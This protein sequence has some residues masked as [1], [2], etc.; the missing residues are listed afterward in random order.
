MKTEQNTDKSQ[1]P[2]RIIVEKFG[3]TRPAIFVDGIRRELH[4]DRVLSPSEMS[5]S[6]SAGV[7][8]LSE[9]Q[10]AAHVMTT[11]EVFEQMKSLMPELY[12]TI[13][14]MP[15]GEEAY[16]KAAG[17]FLT[18]LTKIDVR[19]VENRLKTKE[20]L[21]DDTFVQSIQNIFTDLFAPVAVSPEGIVLPVPHKK[22]GLSMKFDLKDYVTEEIQSQK[23]KP[24][25]AAL[26][27]F[28]TS[29]Y[30]SLSFIAK[31]TGLPGAEGWIAGLLINAWESFGLDVM[32]TEPSTTKGGQRMSSESRK[33]IKTLFQK[34]LLYSVP[35]AYLLDAGFTGVGIFERYPLPLDGGV[36]TKALSVAGRLFIAGLVAVAPEISLNAISR[37]LKELFG[38]NR[39]EPTLQIQSALPEVDNVPAG[40]YKDREG[41]LRRPIRRTGYVATEPVRHEEKHDSM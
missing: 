26:V 40:F 25:I 7:K 31:G 20:P 14:R 11:A 2:D 5:E 22:D 23:I 6:L 24:L 32:L 28:G 17:E 15:N 38:R 1:T 33:A 36:G 8:L 16:H 30:F 18:A 4:I 29:A 37:Y 21:K 41:R 19:S 12:E 39:E 35:V 9:L 3:L 34:I 13:S 10:R 27:V